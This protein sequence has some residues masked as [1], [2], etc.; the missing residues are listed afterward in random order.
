AEKSAEKSAVVTSTMMD[1]LSTRQKEILELM[2]RDKPYSRQEIAD[3][4]GMKKS[5]TGQLLN[6]LVSLDLITAT[7]ATRYRRYVK[8]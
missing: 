6:E 8:K 5:R 3:A 1:S 7:G 2:E 4:L